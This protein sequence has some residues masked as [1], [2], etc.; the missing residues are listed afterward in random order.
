[1]LSKRE[2][3]AERLHEGFRFMKLDWEDTTDLS[4]PDLD[5]STWETVDVPHDWAIG[6]D[7][8]ED[9]DASHMEIDADGITKPIRHTGRTGAL[10]HIGCGW[11]RLPLDLP[12]ENKG[13]RLEL[14]LDGVMWESEV[15]FNGQLVGRNHFGY[16]SYAVDLTPY[17][18]FG[19]RNLLAIRAVVKPDCSRWYPGA[20]IYRN[21]YL[22]T[23]A[24]D[25]IAYCGIRTWIRDVSR[26][27]AT[28]T[29]NVSTEGCADSF[30][31][32]LCSPDGANVLSG[33]G[34]IVGKTGVY[35]AKIDSPELWSLTKRNLYT[36][37]VKTFVSGK[38]T[39]S[40]CVRIGFRD[41]RFDPQKGFFLN[42]EAL[43][44]KGVCNHHDLGVF[45]AA[46]NLSALR[47]QL[48]VMQE[49]GVNA[50]RTSHNPPA[51]ELLDLC[52]EMGFLVIDEF[53]D[54]WRIPKV[55]NGYAQYFDEHAE[56]DTAAIIRRDINHP[57]VVMWSLGNEIGEI[58][59]PDGWQVE[60]LLNDVCHRE[61]PTRPTTAGLNR[62]LV[63]EKNGLFEHIDVVGLNYFPHHYKALH[64]KYPDKVFYGSE[65]ASCISTRGEYRLPAVVE[66]PTKP[67]EELT[68]SD[69]ALSSTSWSYHPDREFVAQEDVPS[70]LGEFVWTGFDYLGEPTPY[71][72]QWPARSSYFGI[73]DTAGLPKSRFYQYKSQWSDKKVLFVMPHWNFEGR[74]GETVPV[75]IF[76]N[77]D[78]VELFVNGQSMGVKEKSREVADYG[79]NRI[80]EGN[81][82]IARCRIVYEDVV[83]APG[84]LVAVALGENGEELARTRVKTAGE[85]YTIKLVP[86]RKTITADGEDACFVRAYVVDRY[87][88]VCPTA[89]NRIHFRAEGAGTLYA[90]DNGDPRE[91]DGYFRP[92]KKVLNGACVAVI[93]SIKGRTGTVDLYA[94]AEGL[95]SCAAT[96]FAKE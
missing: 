49:M 36:L 24:E 1:M 21:A 41:C 96:V 64:E 59:E 80:I 31:I 65:T 90:T 74:E 79:P 76:T 9:N 37:R 61:D 35:T 15:Y 85:P 13:K 50:I 8:L 53:F 39:D 86:E 73:V 6:H 68:V 82:D 77:Y 91:T 45:G 66:M 70:N 16:R 62:P 95:V 54:E 71:Y 55:S 2:R 12:A 72:S 19:T 42:G 38:K 14:I 22:V 88:Y 60:K 23:K 7:F 40:D 92:D 48:T 5:D 63:A 3:T 28:L 58:G 67:N 26:E 83:Y 78:R 81:P 17:A 43:K 44:F 34:M 4:T 32:E 20:G 52:D 84:E 69:Y 18:K 25:S 51:P 56:T 75:H 30:E 29:V 57:S 10:P 46:I 94:D 11:Y 33:R 87:G 27:S 47:R 89:S 93:K